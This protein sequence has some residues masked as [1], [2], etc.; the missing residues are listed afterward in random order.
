[1]GMFDYVII[2][3]E[4]E[5]DIPI[6]EYQTKGLNCNLDTYELDK[7]LQ[8][9]D[10]KGDDIKYNGCMR[11]LNRNTD[12]EVF[13]YVVNGEITQV[14]NKKG[15][16]SYDLR[17]V[18]KDELPEGKAE[19]AYVGDD[20]NRAIGKRLPFITE[21]PETYEDGV[22]VNN[23]IIINGGFDMWQRI[24]VKITNLNKLTYDKVSRSYKVNNSTLTIKL[25][26][27]LRKRIKHVIGIDIVFTVTDL[28]RRLYKPTND[29][30]FPDIGM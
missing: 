5:L 14:T 11:L 17:Y 25:G 18:S 2:K 4:N 22:I 1:M 19:F 26:K 28:S 13:L 6:G 8:F 23:N 20:Y 27:R 9:K 29:T 7:T 16:H 15:F 21:V 3:E 24:T 30:N 10:S 12:E